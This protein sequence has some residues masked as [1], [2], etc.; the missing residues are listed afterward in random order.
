MRRRTRRDQNEVAAS[1]LEG[2]ALEAARIDVERL[3]R[4][5]V[6]AVAPGA[7]LDEMLRDGFTAVLDFVER[8]VVAS[9]L[10]LGETEP[11]EPARVAVLGEVRASLATLLKARFRAAA[12]RAGVGRPDDVEA[13]LVMH[14]LIGLAEG[15]VRAWLL[16]QSVDRGRVAELLAEMTHAAVTPEPDD[17]AHRTGRLLVAAGSVA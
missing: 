9:R 15:G 7:A 11:A 10:L 16:E 2:Q 14:A 5:M 12:E 3:V 6:T 1:V 4:R 17:R 8:N 13:W